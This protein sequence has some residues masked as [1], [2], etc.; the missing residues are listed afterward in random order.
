MNNQ[1]SFPPTYR[2]PMQKASENLRQA[3]PLINKHKIPVNP[4]NYAVWYEYVS[5]ENCLLVD[6][7]NARL[8]N[9]LPI[10]AEFTQELFEKYVLMGMPERL[11]STNNGLKLVVDNTLG[12]INKTEADAAHSISELNNSKSLLNNCRDI[13]ELHNLVSD[14][15]A[16]TQMLTKAS[17]DLKQDLAKSSQEIA[18]L[19]AELEAVKEASRTDGLTGLLNR[20]T[21]NHELNAI[22]E[23]PKT[24]IALALFDLDHFKN[25][26][27][28]YGHVIGDKILQYFSRLLQKHAGE[29]HLVARYGGEEIAMLLMDI[30]LEEARSITDKIRQALADSRLKKKGKDEYIEQVTVSVGLSMLQQEDSP[31]SIIERADKALYYSKNQGRNQVNIL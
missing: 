21:F 18:K 24:N 7:I 3:L 6:E 30:S 11:E 27:D 10:S 12:H 2:D 15:L 26:N 4:A 17:E 8:S 13:N 14:I 1:P 29:D 25:I 20:G 19:K 16:S 9:N 31:S 5:G 28:T 23:Q 22:C